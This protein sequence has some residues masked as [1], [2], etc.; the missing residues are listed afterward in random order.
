[1]PISHYA[2]EH[3]HQLLLER[4]KTEIPEYVKQA[5]KDTRPSRLIPKHRQGQA[6]ISCGEDGIFCGKAWVDELFSQ[7]DPGINVQ[8]QVNDADNIRTGQTLATVSGPAAVLLSAE[9]TLLRFLKTLSGAATHIA[10]CI[11]LLSGDVTRFIDTLSNIS[12]T[13]SLKYALLT[14]AGQSKRL[15]FCDTIPLKENH[16]IAC[17]SVSE[18]I[19]NA[20]WIDPDRPVE[21]EVTSGEQLAEAIRAGA[22][23]I[24]L[25]NFTRGDTLDAITAVRQSAVQILLEAGGNI[26]PDQLQELSLTGI[27]YISADSLI[28]HY[29][30]LDI[31]LQFIATAG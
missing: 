29:R 30:P 16:I 31:S 13:D 27:D 12:G 11:S 19:E 20:R 25:R 28:R 8:W 1:M 22:N 7:L 21:I 5:L 18:A 2:A 3:S 6:I 24:L 17:G 15:D 14:G 23:I 10:H 26:S 4:I 9:S